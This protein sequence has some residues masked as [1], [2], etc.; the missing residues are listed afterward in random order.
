VSGSSRDPKEV[1]R[2]GYDAIAERYAEWAGSFESP[3]P[4]QIE[5]ARAR[6]AHG[7]FLVADATRLELEPESFDGV[8]SLFM[9]G[10]VPREEQGPLLARMGE[11][12]RP[13]GTLLVTMGTAASEDEVEE[14]WL[15]APMFFA[16]FD[17]ETNRGLVDAAG[18]EIVRERV[19]AQDEPG[20][21]P[22]SFMWVLAARV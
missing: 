16:S 22:V 5:R 21:G 2:S 8:M 20:H 10:H 1:V 15:G 12:L 7:S 9:F 19:V 4:V 17:P 14:D 6:I 13:G 18:F 3:S 11:W